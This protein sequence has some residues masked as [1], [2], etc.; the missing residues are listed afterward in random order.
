MIVKYKVFKSSE[1]FE[2]WQIEL[3]K[4]NNTVYIK[5]VAPYYSG[6]FGFSFLLAILKYNESVFVT[7]QI[8]D[9]D[10]LVN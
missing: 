2:N 10:E 6:I 8:G 5:T 1:E 3:K 9:E 4:K 7:Y